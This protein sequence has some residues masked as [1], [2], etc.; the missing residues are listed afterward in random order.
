MEPAA[1]SSCQLG[2]LVHLTRPP[3][4]R[5]RPE[6]RVCSVASEGT[7]HRE[8]QMVQSE[9]R[10]SSGNLFDFRNPTLLIWEIE[11]NLTSLRCED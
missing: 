10:V 7:L 9:S 6:P 3:G 5:R 8:G 1:H 2:E 4:P 11:I